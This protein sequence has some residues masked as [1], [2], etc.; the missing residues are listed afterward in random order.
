METK[1]REII[2][3]SLSHNQILSILIE[4]EKLAREKHGNVIRYYYDNQQDLEYSSEFDEMINNSSWENFLP[5]EYYILKQ[6]K[7]EKTERKTG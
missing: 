1:V 5:S 2:F 7:N 3:K 6:L 4:M